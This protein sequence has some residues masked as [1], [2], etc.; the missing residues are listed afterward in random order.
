MAV[1]AL[2]LHQ[3]LDLVEAQLDLP[4]IDLTRDA[5]GQ[6]VL[7]F[8]G[9]LAAMKLGDTGGNEGLDNLLG[10]ASE[11][12]DPRLAALRLVRVTAPSLQFV[13]AVSKDRTT[14]ADPV[15]ELE[16]VNGVWTASLSGRLG[17]GRIEATG[18]PA[19][20]P[21]MQ[22]VTIQ[23]QHLRAKD[24]AAFAPDVPLA[25]ATCPALRHGR[26]HHRSGDRRAGRGDR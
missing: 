19:A 13:D 16:R 11:S 26:I 21:P 2:L 4:G 25:G 7:S 6:L 20:T 1:R 8:G 10:G 15:F 14:A 17:D 23:F 3:Q 24:F 12:S 18:E 9:K 22:Q 5:D